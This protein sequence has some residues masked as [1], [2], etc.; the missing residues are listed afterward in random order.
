MI[1]RKKNPGTCINIFVIVSPLNTYSQQWILIFCFYWISLT[2]ELHMYMYMLQVNIKFWLMIMARVQRKLR[3]SLGLK[4]LTFSLL[5]PLKFCQRAC[6]VK[7]KILT[8]K[9]NVTALPPVAKTKVR[10]QRCKSTSTLCNVHVWILS[11]AVISMTVYKM[12]GKKMSY[13]HFFVS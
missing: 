11:M 10:I 13:R 6:L 7:F 3:I 9:V 2:L 1:H 8:C 4:L 5:A 12:A